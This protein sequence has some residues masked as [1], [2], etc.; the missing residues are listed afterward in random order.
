M[1]KFSLW[2]FGFYVN[3]CKCFV[4]NSNFNHQQNRHCPLPGNY[5]Q[6]RLTFPFPKLN[7]DSRQL[8]LPLRQ[9]SHNKNEKKNTP[10]EPSREMTRSP[11]RLPRGHHVVAKI[12][13]VSHLAVGRYTFHSSIR[14]KKKL[15]ADHLRPRAATIIYFD[16]TV[17][18]LDAALFS[19][20]QPISCWFLLALGFF[21]VNSESMFQPADFD[22]AHYSLG[23]RL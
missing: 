11:N 20:N 10:L 17:L 1:Y 5:A 18:D 13:A 4:K 15:R 6:K 2:V 23:Y 8:L 12:V 19:P 7:H 14:A 3:F 9:K 22:R 16:R 21:S